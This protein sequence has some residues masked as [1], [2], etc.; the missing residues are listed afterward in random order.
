MHVAAGA[1]LGDDD[2]QGDVPAADNAQGATRGGS[3][4]PRL[5]VLRGG[6]S[7][8]GLHEGSGQREGRGDPVCAI[9]DHGRPRVQLSCSGQPALYLRSESPSRRAPESMLHFSRRAGLLMLCGLMPPALGLAACSDPSGP[10]KPA[11]IALSGTL[12][13]SAPVGSSLSPSVLVTDANG[14]PVGGVDVTF[15]ASAGGTVAA[16]SARTND[17]GIASPGSWTLS[18]TVGT[19]T[20]TVRAGSSASL[21][22]TVEGVGAEAADIE[23]YGTYATTG[24]I[25]TLVTGVP[26]VR[27]VDT[28]GN[29]VP[30]VAVTFTTG[31]IGFVT[32]G[33]QETNSQG[34]A[35]PNS[36]M[37]GAT[38]GEQ[39]LTAQV[40]A[41][42]RQLTA[43]ITITALAPAPLSKFAGEGT[44]CPVNTTDC[45]FSVLVSAA[46]ATP[47]AGETIE[48]TAQDG[49]T[50][51][52]T[53][54]TR[55]IASAPNL[56]A[57]STT[58]TATQTAR[59][60][61]TGDNV[62]FNFQFV[63]P[64]GYTLD[65]RY[66][67]DISASQKAVLD[68]V[69]RRW[70]RVITGNLPQVSMSV[71][72]GECFDVAHPSFNGTV[73]D[74]VIFMVFDSI[75]GVGG[76][77]GRAGPCYVRS[78]SLLPVFG[79]MELDIDD[80]DD[81]TVNGMLFDVMLHEVG[82]VIGFGTMWPTF[83]L[84]VGHGGSNPFFTGSRALS[85]FVLAGGTLV[86]GVPIENCR[87]DQGQPL[88]K[89]GSATRD[90]HWREIVFATELM[91]GFIG[92][93]PNPM[94]T[95]TIASLMDMGYQ[96]NFGAA[97]SFAMPS[98]AAALRL[99]P[100]AA[101]AERPHTRP[102]PA[103]RTL[104]GY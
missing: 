85:A 51:T 104:P 94:S 86:D 24:T 20:L 22:L 57:R 9:S 15:T 8:R 30:G 87:N 33:E 58:G 28:N 12:P 21:T 101:D 39:T 32:G 61:S 45:R 47:V 55:G 2:G 16:G 77:L 81:L 103:P 92:N 59:R 73:D 74:L 37:L 50:I 34:V 83:E 13:A 56:Y 60:V 3:E 66:V 65:L 53:T 70:E 80:V 46:D 14:Q 95:V 82:H 7:G 1:R 75:D 42:G 44:T 41:S 96:V 40:I 27:V 26:S 69:G 10:P 29:G 98:G 91:T 35:R 71:D 90:G 17:S 63:Q 64:G 19:N 52:T 72:A 62:V 78:S 31:G 48:W 93:P 76:T 5:L 84:M 97:D 88:E 6:R 4:Q 99:A 36:W 49:T 11:K 79:V 38:P 43:T 25:N 54:N 18:T 67:G 68:S 23:P 100:I 102:F 89:C